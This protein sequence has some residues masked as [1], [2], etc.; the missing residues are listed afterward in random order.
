MNEYV[1]RAQQY[2]RDVLNGV[3]P[4]CKWTRLAV[5]RQA[6]DL[7]RP[8]SDEWPWIFDADRAA[9]PCAFA[10]LLPHIKGKWA[11]DGKRLELEP[12]QCF[13]LTTVYGWVHHETRLRRFLEA[14]EEEARKNGKSAK[15]S[16]LLLYML[17]ADGEHGAECYTAATTRDQARIVF[18]DAKA[19]A[20]RS[21]GLRTHLGVAI[22]QHSL[23]VAHTSSKAAPLAAEG[24]T[25]DGLNVHFAL[26]DEL[27]AHKTR[28]VYDVIDSARGAREQSL[29]WTIT[30]AGTDRSGICYERRTHVT[31][32][33][34]RVVQDERVFGIIYTLD[35]GDDHFDP[36]VWI[37]ANPNLGKSV[38]LDEL[39][40]QASK[41]QAMPSAL[42]NF[43]TK[44]LNVWVSGESPWMDMRAWERCGSAA[45]G[46]ESIPDGAKVY[47]GL[48][49]A[50]KKD[51][52][53]LALAWQDDA[54]GK[55]GV[56]TR[57]YL[58]EL[59]IQ[60]SGN[61]HL[62]GWARQGYVVVTDGDLTDFDVVAD[63]MR[64]YCRRFAVQEIA[65]DPALSMYF[66]GKL[67]EEG[68]PLVEIS[69]RA[70]FF[71]PAL[72][73]VENMVREGKL[74]HEGNPVMGWMVSNLVVKQSKFNELMA[75]VKE[76]PENKID[77]PM[78]MLMA[79]GRALSN[80]RTET[81][82]WETT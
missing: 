23:T 46:I 68:L 79:L 44:R 17:T 55:W 20:E 9:R 72:I 4:T 25:L 32:I 66:A 38:Q 45:A 49:L 18:D 43:L 27:H 61:A 33:L 54:T 10:E 50:Q 64:T 63:D 12:W 81:S 28:A 80:E 8:V 3:I 47:M 73:Q 59:A 41:A 22:M 35:D 5:Q 40:A 39:M 15:G 65:F 48:D 76:R 1:E 29:L 14:Y 30:T 57:L 53:A 58:N 13:I 6:D 74:Q 26:L 7:A 70:V 34:D 67:I 21:P 2:M 56:C 71:T 19:M 51:F 24:S 62:A 75:P 60:E 36:A 31:K 69:Q 78:A 11:R 16:A 77:G 42:S 52:A 37:K 82:F